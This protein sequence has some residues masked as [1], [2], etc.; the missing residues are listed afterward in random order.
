[1]KNRFAWLGVATLTALFASSTARADEPLKPYVVLM[2]D[3]SGSMN[4]ATG[5]GPP[6]CGGSDTRLNHA[7]CAINRIVNSYGDM[8]FALGRFR[9]TNAG[10][11][12]NSCTADCSS[13]GIYCGSCDCNDRTEDCSSDSDCTAALES[14]LR[15]EMLTGLVDGGN[16]DAAAWTDFACEN[17]GGSGTPSTSQPEIFE[18]SSTSYT[19]LEGYMR[20][21]QRYW[22]GLQASDGVSGTG[23]SFAKAGNVITLTD[24]AGLFQTAHIGRRVTIAGATSAGNNGSF[25]IASRPSST[26]ITYTNAAGVAQAYTGTWTVDGTTIWPSTA[27]GF[28]PINT[29]P[30]RTSFLPK[31]GKP[32]TCNP[33]PATCDA[34]AGCSSTTN[35]CCLEQCRPYI[36]IMLT[37]GAETCGGDATIPIADMLT[38]DLNNR[39]YVVET[40]AIGFGISPGDADIEAFAHA[41]GAADIALADEGYYAEDEAG[42]QLAIS[43]I[44]ADA[45]KTETCNTRDDDCDTFIDEGFNASGTCNNG[46]AGK[47]RVNGSLACRLDGTGAECSAGVAACSGHVLN[48]ACTVTNTAG[49]NVPG[50]CQTGNPQLVCVPTPAASEVPTGCNDIDDDC[51]GRIDE[52]VTG[53]TCI[54][55]GEECDGEDDD[56]DGDI[57]EDLERPCGSGVCAGV[58]RCNPATGEW[59]GP[60]PYACTADPSSPE[61]CNGEDDDCDGNADGFSEACSNMAGSFPALDPRNNPGGAHTPQ[62]PCELLG[63]QCICHPGVRQCPLNGTGT[64]GACINE[65]TPRT[66]ICNDLDDD[67]DGAVDEAPM[68]ACTTN[69][70]CPP[71]TP[72]CT[73]PSGN[74]N[75]GTCGPADCSTNCGIGQLVCVNGMQVCNA[76]QAP[77]DD[78]CNNVDDDC[79]MMIDEDWVCSDPTNGCPCTDPDVCNGVEKCLAGNVVCQGPP[80]GQETCNCL[81]DNCNGDTDE[82]SLCPP[83][84]DCTSFCQCAFHCSEGEFPCPLGKQCVDTYC[85]ADPCFQYTC[86]D[87]PGVKRVCIDVM[88]APTCVDACSLVTCGTGQV[89]VPSLGE[90]R[91]DNCITFPE[92]CEANENC[93]AGNCV[94]NPC[95]NV[96]CGDDQYCVGGQCISSCADVECPDGQRCRM[97]ACETD[98]CG[99][100]CPFGQACHDDT[101]ECIS[102]PCRFQTC[103]QGQWC[104]PNHNGQCEDDPCVGTQCPDQSQVCKGGTC[105]D[106]TVFMPDAGVETHVTTGGGGGCHTGSD[107]GLLAGLALLLMRRRRAARSNGGRS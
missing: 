59:G 58:E 30:T 7:R 27:G 52:G 8:V 19:P 102:D 84:S 38:T 106:P 40:K 50:T 97:G 88:S 25:I 29:D 3:T 71:I 26:Q 78:T 80:I 86:P 74:P 13:S 95:S 87:V 77:D 79:D 12:V 75:A 53:C 36:T 41:G 46:R 37:D 32:A 89:C 101:G 1:M 4:S 72:T 70:Q 28:N 76:T 82:G 67:C 98:P 63:T 34:S 90:C 39:R 92:Y 103:P 31:A 65:Q 9:M 49:A 17:C 35:C 11:Y 51:D 100:P 24:S 6:S 2:V 20:S 56:C 43:A 61:T 68:T 83:G 5:S 69:A 48:Q 104:N 107:V 33:N 96:T 62:S 10:T 60:P 55:F 44:L 47:C 21:A 64:W 85:I 66:E 105:Y 22:E 42:L 91:P 45:I 14:D 94:S 73:N 18:V 54:P 93:I 15:G 16:D 81:D 57:D 99:G 23:D